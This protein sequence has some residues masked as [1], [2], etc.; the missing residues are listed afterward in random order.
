MD[1][2]FDDTEKKD[3]R[4]GLEKNFFVIIRRRKVKNCG[5]RRKK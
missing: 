4:R 5:G 2:Q 1:T 3:L